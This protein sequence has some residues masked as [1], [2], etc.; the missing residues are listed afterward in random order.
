MRMHRGLDTPRGEQGQVAEARGGGGMG[1]VRYRARSRA[2][3]VCDSDHVLE[4]NPGE[5]VYLLQVEVV[6][7][8]RQ[9][10][11]RVSAQAHCQVLLD[12]VLQIIDTNIQ[13]EN[14]ICTSHPGF[15][16]CRAAWWGPPGRRRLTKL[17][18]AH[19]FTLNLLAPC[20][21]R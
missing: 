15:C 6:H 16:T 13:E 8:N 4:A 12:P 5:L 20:T 1:D 3:P 9:V 18:D 21:I 10:R 11:R 17:W 7:R 19:P 14:S 2:V